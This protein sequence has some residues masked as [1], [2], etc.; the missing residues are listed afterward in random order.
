MKSRLFKTGRKSRRD[1]IANVGSWRTTITKE[2][3]ID[4]RASDV[5]NIR[6]TL[7]TSKLDQETKNNSGQIQNNNLFRIFRYKGVNCSIKGDA[8][9]SFQ[10]LVYY[11]D[12]LGYTSEQID[13]MDFE[14]DLQ[15]IDMVNQLC[16]AVLS[17]AYR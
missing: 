15:K 8:Y 13:A 1:D 9:Y 16:D 5:S 17:R 14:N 2:A 12:H 6:V 10:Y 7:T 3:L 4:V 11:Q